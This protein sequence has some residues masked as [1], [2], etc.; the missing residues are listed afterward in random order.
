MPRRGVAGRAE[1]GDLKKF[2]RHPPVPDPI[3]AA[4]IALLLHGRSGCLVILERIALEAPMGRGLPD[5]HAKP[6][7]GDSAVRGCDTKA[8]ASDAWRFSFMR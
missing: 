7:A 4:S 5:R 8:D 2:R 3:F 1:A 6:V